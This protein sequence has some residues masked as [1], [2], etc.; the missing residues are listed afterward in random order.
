M[1]T[2]NGM[3]AIVLA[4]G[5]GKRMKSSLP[6]VLHPIAERPLLAWVVE[7]ALEAGVDRVVAVVG[8][9]RGAVEAML[10]ARFGDRVATVH[11]PA[12]MG[13]GH[14]VRCALPAFANHDGDVLILYG[15]CPLIPANAIEAL[16]AAK[17][18]SGKKLALLTATI[19]DPT[20]YGRIVRGADG[21]VAAIV[22]HRDASDAERAIAEVNPGI[23]AIDAA[24]LRQALDRL[25]S[26]NDQ[27]EI[28][29]TDVVAMAAAAGGVAD[30]SWDMAELRG[31][32]D[33]YELALCAATMRLR[34][35]RRHA[36]E[37]V[38]IRDPAHTDIG[39]DVT[40]GVDAV[41]ESGVV[42]R[43]RTTVGERA[44][45]DVGS[46]LTDVEVGRDAEVKPYTVAAESRIG[47]AAHVGPFS[48]LRPASELG[49]EAHVGNFVEIKKTTMGRG[50]KA[51]HLA[52]LGDGI[53]G[54]GVNVGAGT[55]FCNYDGFQKHTTVLE[56][57]AFI[58]SDSQL[59]APVR[60]GKGA[61]VATGTTVTMDVPDDGLALSRVKQQNK[62][63][64]ASRLRA[65]LAAAKKAAMAKATGGK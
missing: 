56:D 37:G 23:Y 36:L 52:Y 31:I 41:I 29:L 62:E 58:G 45:I 55:I 4:A 1:S 40:I 38:T 48:H 65:R 10:V 27:G 5:E 61:Y 53:I 8:H 54:E 34:I 13:T 63:G 25:G 22:E 64:Y 3:I 7:A 60:V 46:V 51:N 19:G 20:G 17:L 6:K 24:F 49:P 39:A 2:G 18:A 59:V 50:S 35:A 12:Q 43:G 21:A 57:G 14:A 28:Y 47:D 15:D 9:G 42:L 44:R 32:N 26:D 30:V 33:R 16:G 11:Q